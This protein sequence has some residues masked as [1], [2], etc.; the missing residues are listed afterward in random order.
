M[1][2]RISMGGEGVGFEF[3][4]I[5]R[6]NVLLCLMTKLRHKGGFP[7]SGGEQVD[8]PWVSLLWCDKLPLPSPRPEMLA[9][10][11]LRIRWSLTWACSVF[12][13][14]LSN[15][16]SIHLECLN[17]KE[18]KM[19]IISASR[20][21]AAA[22]SL[23]PSLSAC[24]T[25]QQ[26]WCQKLSWRSKHAEKMPRLSKDVSHGTL[27]EKR[28]PLYLLGYISTYTYRQPSQFTASGVMEREWGDRAGGR[29]KVQK[30]GSGGE[31]TIGGEE[32]GA[33]VTQRGWRGG[34]RRRGPRPVN[35][36]E[37]QGPT[38]PGS[39]SEHACMASPANGPQIDM[40]PE[41]TPLISSSHSTPLSL[42]LSPIQALISALWRN[43]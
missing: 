4:L 8:F 40:L 22:S 2:R 25:K 20:T 23:L 15:R 41:Q 1:L 3:D 13:T 17:R 24:I 34:A 36:S 29:K 6:D 12:S 21:T 32:G 19:C 31:R 27:S 16:P 26:L 10:F 5:L 35:Y 37:E 7:Y 43:V 42:P 38:H 39:R 33:Q 18:Q 28:S 9:R 14:V 30:T 11:Q